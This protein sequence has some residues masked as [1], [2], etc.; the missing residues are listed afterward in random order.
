MSTLLNYNQRFSLNGYSL[1]G[2][3][4]LSFE[5]DFGINY[6]PT[7]GNK[8]F[9]FNKL[10][11]SVGTVEFSRSLIY[12]DPVLNCTGE[13]A[14]SGLF[15]TSSQAYSFTSGYLN[16]YSVSCGIGQV[17][18][19][20]STFS[21]FGEMKTGVQNFS[22]A[23]HPD[24][25]VPSQKS[26]SISGDFGTSNRVQ[27][28]NYSLNIPRQPK[29]SLGNGLFPDEVTLSGPIQ[30]SASISFNVRNLSFLD[31]NNFVRHI[32]VPQF[33]ILVKNRELTET[34]MNLSVTNAQV[35]TQGVVGTIDSP[36]SLTLNYKGFLE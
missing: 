26:I 35:I 19:V 23:S 15:N 34:L 10:G 9:G 13:A 33:N 18:A 14:C 21:I 29:Y 31:L 32:D 8:V 7:L 25:F 5:S 24:I 2:I 20:N 28:F 3:S 30:I 27:S 12:A 16:S 6:T 11:P 1:S 4:D 36:L 17:P 22:A